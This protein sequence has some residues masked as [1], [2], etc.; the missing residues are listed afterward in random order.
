MHNKTQGRQIETTGRDIGCDTDACAFAAQGLHRL[1][2]F[3]LRMF[4]RKCH[5]TETA[6]H[7]TR[8][9]TTNRFARA[10]EQHRRFRFMETQQID[11]RIFGVGRGN[12]DRLIGNI[13]MAT[14]FA[15]GGN[16][17]RIILVA[18][19]K[20]NDRFRHG[21]REQ[22]S[23]P[24]F[25]GCVENFLKIFAKAHV[26]HFV[27]FIENHSAQVFQV[28]RTAFKMV[29]QTARGADNDMC[30]TAQGPALFRSVHTADTGRNLGTG[31]LIKP[32]QFATHLQR[33]LAGRSDHQCQRL[34][35]KRE[36]S[37]VVEHLWCHGETESDRLARTGLG[38]H[39]QI[40]AIRFRFEHSGLNRRRLVIFVR[41]KRL[42]EKRR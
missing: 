11:H 37:V 33:K 20:R 8:M 18:F 13:A 3:A 2:A 23:P 26:E 27:R 15:N 1:I 19:G 12:G 24:L 39:D 25:A 38:R 22:Q 6:I 4:T 16:A 31:R 21:C 7:E 32:C 10:A 30:A 17:Q 34:D 40:S 42:S 29:A 14:V 36:T 9:Q 35:Q 5:R 28:E 41:R